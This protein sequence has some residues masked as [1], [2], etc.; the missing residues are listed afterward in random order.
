MEHVLTIKLILTHLCSF[1]SVSEIYS[2]AAHNVGVQVLAR[3][4]DD[5]NDGWFYRLVYFLVREI[6]L[7]LR[8]TINEC[9]D[10]GKYRVESSEGLIDIDEA[11]IVGLTPIETEL[12]VSYLYNL[13]K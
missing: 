11:D 4:P 6:R 1:N 10:S 3:M 12:K 2:L 8:V 5:G 13:N 7:S 9:N